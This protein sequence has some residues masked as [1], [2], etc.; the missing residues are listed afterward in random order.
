MNT[1][2]VIVKDKAEFETRIIHMMVGDGFGPD[3]VMDH[4]ADYGRQI[5][6]CESDTATLRVEQAVKQLY[7]ATTGRRF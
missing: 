2:T 5:F 6:G 1:Q 3:E 7:R 4:A